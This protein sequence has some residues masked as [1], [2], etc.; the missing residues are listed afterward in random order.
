[1][2]TDPL[3]T[4]RFAPSPNGYLHLGHALSAILNHDLAASN[5]GRFLVRI[6][7]IDQ[8]RARPAFEDAIFEDLD[9]LGLQWAPDIRRQSEHTDDYRA[10]LARLDAL[11]L[12]RRSVATRREIAEAAAAAE[13]AGTPWR[14][15]PD[16]AW[17]APPDEA[18]LTT[19]AIATRIATDAP[20]TLRLK[21]RKAI[22]HLAI[23]L[24]FVEEDAG[25][26]GETGLIEADPTLWGD[27]V[28]AR[29]DAAASYHLSVV[30]DDAAQGI[31]HVVRGRDL[32]YATAIHRLLQALLDLPAPRYRHHRLITD[33]TGRKLSK[34][35][36]DTSLRELRDQG[37]TPADIR[38]KIGI[39]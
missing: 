23:D 12:V 11:G 2:P 36:Q 18:F 8:T 30:V 6:D 4:Y 25:P 3:P 16:G 31:T 33:E 34:S 39:G 7:D 10:A 27:V 32:F 15:D 22:A 13:K 26:A 14:R 9:W 19:D 21:T 17:I 29:S 1:M 38:R 5:N 24:A 37:A 28:L 35:S 20:A